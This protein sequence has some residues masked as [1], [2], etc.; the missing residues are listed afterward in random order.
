MVVIINFSLQL[1]SMLHEL[2]LALYGFPGGV[3]V[4]SCKSTDEENEEVS[5]DCLPVRELIPVAKELPFI[6]QAELAIH[7]ELV[8][9]GS[10]Y[11]FL[12]RF[13]KRYAVPHQSLYI[14]AAACGIDKALDDYRQTVSSLEL[15]LLKRPELNVTH[16]S[17]RLHTFKFLL[18]TLADL[19]KKLD[20]SVRTGE[21]SG[22]QYGCRMLDTIWSA[23]PVGLP[24]SRASVRVVLVHA[25][26]V[27]Y[28]QLSSWLLHGVLHDPHN[29]FFIEHV[30]TGTSTAVPDQSNQLCVD[31]LSDM[32]KA[33]SS[34]RNQSFRIVPSRI[35]SFLA[36]S[37]AH[38]VLFSG[39][40]LHTLID[41][42]TSRSHIFS[43]VEKEF[44]ER[45]DHLR[46]LLDVNE[47]A[48]NGNTHNVSEYDINYCLLDIL[49]LQNLISDIRTSVSKRIWRTLV[50]E[51]RLVEHLTLVKDV[52]LLG[53]GEL[54]L[55]FCDQ[56]LSH[57]QRF[58]CSVSGD[59][60]ESAKKGLLDHAPP[61]S[62]QEARLL[63]TNVTAVFLA[64]VRSVGLDD[65]VIGE[66]F[67]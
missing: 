19:A 43:E 38:H 52:I 61:T 7:S 53:R 13:I 27:F 29:E 60:A 67:R 56:L 57:T 26:R 42:N 45:F 17:Y 8:K 15:E 30:P 11:M 31:L 36:A 23:V 49:P 32:L 2:L 22:E 10:S 25:M 51:L 64:A 6:P 12:D 5:T 46:R 34:M 50:E 41:D 39:E 44:S 33:P 58:S 14:S 3:F 62:A 24:A 16:C 18:P 54:F 40:A 1:Q 48:N 65:D 47:T 63:E 35:P 20:R 4:E 9:L 66:R 21:K 59:S 55:A 28:R 37:F